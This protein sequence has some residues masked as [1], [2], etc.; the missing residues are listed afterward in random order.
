MEDTCPVCCA[1][2]TAV[3]RRPIQCPSC[4]Y[5]ACTDCFKR[6]ILSMNHDAD[7]M[8][9]HHPFDREL[10]GKML[11]R[12]FVDKDY[13]AHRENVLV[14][15]EMALLPA[16]QHAVA[17]YKLAAK[18]RESMYQS[19]VLMAEYTQMVRNL[20]AQRERESRQLFRILRAH[21]ETDG[22]AGGVTT[23]EGRRERS[24]FLRGCPAPDCRG[25]ITL[26]HKCGTC[27][28][29]VCTTCLEALEGP[30]EEHTCDPETAATAALIRRDTKPCP[31]CA[32]MITKVDGC[33]QMFCTVCHI[34][35]SW[36]TG[37]VEKGRI[38]NPHYYA[39]LRSTSATGEIP[40]EEGDIPGGMCNEGAPHYHT[41][42]AAL[43]HHGLT[44][45]MVDYLVMTNFHR[46]VVHVL[47]VELPARRLADDRVWIERQNKDLR[48]QYLVGHITRDE[49]KRRLF[50]REKATAKTLEQRQI[51]EMYAAVVGDN[52]R[53]FVAS[54][55]TV[56]ASIAEM[57]AVA[58]HANDAFRSMSN[59]YNCA[60][61]TVYSGGIT[62]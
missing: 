45:Q 44:P 4:Q 52:L 3:K 20:K 27:E 60:L 7:C 24:R 30:A 23:D 25:F 55:K 40:R 61:K 21:Y 62:P 43:A 58:T 51:F 19:S 1:P 48:L 50:A 11:S 56:A 34:A 38:H 16:T 8:Q 53:A 33:D 14:D 22:V 15:R 29:R 35:F 5:A 6:Y 9:C 36:R 46:E 42:R 54:Q 32:A 37:E 13:R 26:N 47:H 39:W 12:S 28:L 57:R 59:R 18:L 2:Y 41:L 49:W 10:L 31:S 17:N